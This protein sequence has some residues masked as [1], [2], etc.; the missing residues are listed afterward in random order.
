M[1]FTNIKIQ[2]IAAF[3]MASG[4]GT[5]AGVSAVLL[6]KDATHENDLFDL[7]TTNRLTCRPRGVEPVLQWCETRVLTTLSVTQTLFLPQL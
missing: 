4:A 7:M 1:Q 5:G 6:W 3:Q 2:I